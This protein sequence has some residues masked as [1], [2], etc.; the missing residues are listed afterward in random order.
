MG[1]S[2]YEAAA[3]ARYRG[4]QLPTEAQWEYAARGQAGRIY[5]WGDQDTPALSNHGQS[6]SPY[7]DISDG[8]RE[9]APVGSFPGGATPEKIYDLAGNVMEWCRDWYDDYNPAE[10]FNPSGPSTGLERV[11]RG[12]SWRGSML[13]I[14]G[15][16]RNRS[17]QNIRYQDGGIRLV[18]NF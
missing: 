12:G 16:H 13:F 3:Y 11:I 9:T 15:F 4:K 2:W 10:T 8:F 17:T 1:V 7:Y 5:P 14:R 6:R 18:R